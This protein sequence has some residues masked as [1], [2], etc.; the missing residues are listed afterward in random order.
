[1]N[2]FLKKNKRKKI[3]ILDIPLFFEK[4]LN[5]KK[6]KVV[7]I[8]SRSKDIK[9]RLVLRQN[10][11]N[12]VH[13]QLKKLQLSLNYKKKRSNYIIKNNFNLIS[14]RKSVKNILNKINI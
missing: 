9:K 10:F 4:K 13:K 8:F 6:D 5:L 3:V 1:M 12:T 7:F 14:A 11:N 2:L